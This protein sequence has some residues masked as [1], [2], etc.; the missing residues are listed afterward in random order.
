MKLAY[1]VNKD[2]PYLYINDVLNHE[3]KLSSRLLSKLIK[4]KK[5]YLNGN[6]CDT[7]EKIKN[8]DI[9]I[10]D[11][12]YPEDNSNIVSAK[13]N[14]KNLNIIYEDDGLLIVSKPSN[15]AVHPSM[16]HYDDTLSNM[17]K[18]YFDNIGLYKK[19]RPVN[20]LDLNTSGLV[21]FAKNEYI[22]ECLIKQMSNNTFKKY[23]LAIVEGKL[24]N[25]SGTINEPIA[26]K[27]N[28]IIERC[29]SAQGQNSITHYNVIYSN[30]NY[31][32]VKCSLETG[33]THQI[34]VHFSFIGHPLLGD[35]LYGNHSNLI[36]RQALHCYFLEFVNPLTNKTLKVESP[37]PDDMKK[38]FDNKKKE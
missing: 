2:C 31:S 28:S 17:V 36:D 14:T 1:K 15:L 26:R 35:T 18:N 3:F 9:I 25:L 11:F 19:I 13:N 29:V 32:I 20:R 16:M 4:L 5:I 27:E 6:T 34:R 21:V 7:R 38:F 23:Y 10:C 33:R 8:G 37:I 30:D 12:D 22:Q 24:N